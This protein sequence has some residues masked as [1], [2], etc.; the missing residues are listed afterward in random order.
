MT[1]QADLDTALRNPRVRA[2]LNAI[3][4]GEG[5]SY[6]TLFGGKTFDNYDDHPNIIVRKRVQG[7]PIAS[8][9][10]GRYQILK[11]TWNS[12]KNKFGL[13][14]FSPLNQD[15]A[16]VGLLI[17]NG[18]LG[19]ILANDIPSAMHKL[20]NVWASLPGNTYGQNGVTQNEFINRYNAAAAIPAEKTLEKANQDML[21]NNDPQLIQDLARY[22]KQT[23][24]NSPNGQ[25]GAAK[26]ELQNPQDSVLKYLSNTPD[27]AQLN[28]SVY[29]AL[30]SPYQEYTPNNLEQDTLLEPPSSPAPNKI[31]E[32]LLQPPASSSYLS[33]NQNSYLSD[34]PTSYLG[35]NPTLGSPDDYNDVDEAINDT[36]QQLKDDGVNQFF[37]RGS[38]NK[39]ALS[40]V[41]QSSIKR[42]VRDVINGD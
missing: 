37:N 24:L 27:D 3:G 35:N 7:K 41:L 10:A 33:D 34:V 13:T 17:N 23:F 9:A 6:N 1:T 15:R 38:V 8:T 22:Q 30:Q 39:L 29:D 40:P 18:A 36:V 32:A 28:N 21:A 31:E 19:D 16:A 2:F 20:R 5:K 42:I 25:L 4:Q 14:D 26:Q 12:L 11:R